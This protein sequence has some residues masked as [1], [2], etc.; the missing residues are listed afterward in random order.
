MSLSRITLTLTLLAS[1]TSYASPVQF[2]IGVDS[3]KGFAGGL[4]TV[5]Y[6]NFIIGGQFNLG[7]SD[8]SNTQ[9]GSYPGITNPTFTSKKSAQHYGLYTGYR[10]NDGMFDGL[11]LRL[12][13]AQMN[14]NVSE[15]V[16]GS[17][18]A[19]N[20]TSEIIYDINK[21]KY[22]PFIGIGYHVSERISLNVHAHLRGI[23]TIEV[24]GQKLDSGFDATTLSF[25]AGFSF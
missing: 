15:D 4:E 22:Q 8:E 12:G 1:A 10:F 14:I 20:V 6:D 21:R 3:H 23:D 18:S 25:M 16:Y 9:T 17:D 5:V 2:L 13:I 24:E 19:S 11:A 7:S